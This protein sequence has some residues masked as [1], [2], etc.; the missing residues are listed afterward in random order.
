MRSVAH[1]VSLAEAGFQSS[2]VLQ[3]RSVRVYFHSIVVHHAY[4]IGVELD[5]EHDAN[6]FWAAMQ[7]RFKLFGLALHD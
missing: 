1:E 5:A 3:Y 4:D 2:K 7:A 6:R